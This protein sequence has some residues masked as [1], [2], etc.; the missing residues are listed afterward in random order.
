MISTEQQFKF[1]HSWNLL[2]FANFK[3]YPNSYSEHVLS[4]DVLNRSLKNGLLYTDRLLVLKQPLP[5]I[6][7]RITKAPTV[8]YFLERSVLDPH[9][10]VMESKT[11]SLSQRELFQAEEI[12]VFENDE[13][14][15]MFTQKANF[16]VFSMFS[17]LIENEALKRFNSNREKGLKGLMSVVES[18]KSGIASGIIS[19]IDDIGAS[20]STLGSSI[21][22]IQHSIHSTVDDIQHTIHSKVDGITH[23]I[24]SKVDGITSDLHNNICEISSDINLK[25]DEF[26]QE[27]LKETCKVEARVEKSLKILER[28]LEEQFIN[29]PF[30]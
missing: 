1:P 2:T 7:Q 22:D 11:Y 14:G 27:L 16:K 21:D 28:V 5:A 30:S 20:I 9:S 19:G 12:C 26:K 24:H 13:T 23:S 6:L 18:I 25:V 29:G 15:T 4:C 8:T 17:N 3:K 10:Q